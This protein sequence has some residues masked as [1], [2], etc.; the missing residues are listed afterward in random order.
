[1]TEDGLILINLTLGSESLLVSVIRLMLVLVL[2][3]VAGGVRLLKLK[4]KAS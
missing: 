2:V 4:Q 3:L 1:M